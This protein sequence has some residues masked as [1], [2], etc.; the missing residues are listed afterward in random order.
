MNKADFLLRYIRKFPE[1][2]FDSILVA[3]CWNLLDQSG[4]ELLG[5]ELQVF[6]LSFRE[7]EL[8]G[9]KVTLAGI[10]GSGLL[11][12]VNFL[13]YTAPQQSDIERRDKWQ[14]MW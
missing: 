10:F 2:T 3:G 11:W 6:D 12:G 5:Y 8:R 1:G 9:I 4:Y 14:G 7:C 13:R